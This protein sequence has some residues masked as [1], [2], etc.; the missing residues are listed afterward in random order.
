VTCRPIPVAL[1]ARTPAG[2]TQSLIT[3]AETTKA[4]P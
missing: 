3:E 1:M 4:L 2:A